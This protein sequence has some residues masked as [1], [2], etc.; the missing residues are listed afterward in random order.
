MPTSECLLLKTEYFMHKYTILA[1]D[2]K[3]L[4]PD[5]SAVTTFIDN[6]SIHFLYTLGDID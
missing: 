3:M 6:L 2:H 1:S 4:D 5:F